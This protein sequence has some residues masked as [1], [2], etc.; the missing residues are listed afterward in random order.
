M[1]AEIV[2][3]ECTQCAFTQVLVKK[4]MC[5]IFAVR[6]KSMKSVKI[7]H[8]KIW[9]YTIV[10]SGFSMT[11]LMS[12]SLSPLLPG[13]EAVKDQPFFDDV[14]WPMLLKEKAKFIPQLQGEEY[15]SYFDS[16]HVINC[17]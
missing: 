9:H 14:N 11:I 10:T 2:F 12:F 4:F 5:L 17:Q 7:M 3:T 16:E 8:L 15:T 13:V 6:G 1:L